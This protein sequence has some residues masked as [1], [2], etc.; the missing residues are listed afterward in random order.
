MNLDALHNWLFD[1]CKSGGRANVIDMM[2]ELAGLRRGPD[3]KLYDDLPFDGITMQERLERLEREGKSVRDGSWWR[4][5]EG[6]PVVAKP[7]EKQSSLF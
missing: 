1:C 5:A 3:P 4:W 6:K 2:A 7:V